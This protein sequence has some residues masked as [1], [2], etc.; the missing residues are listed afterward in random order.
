MSKEHHVD[1]LRREYELVTF[2][3]RGIGESNPDP[4]RARCSRHRRSRRPAMAPTADEFNAIAD[5]NAALFKSC[6]A[7]TG[8]LFRHLSAMDT[9]A[10]VEQMRL[11]LGAEST[12]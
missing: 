4:L 1:E 2:D 6:D 3:P 5:A 7:L 9:A 8:E 11:A 10:D 12:A